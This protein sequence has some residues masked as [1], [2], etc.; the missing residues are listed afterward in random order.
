MSRQQQ[1]QHQRQYENYDVQRRQSPQHRQQQQ[2]PSTSYI[3]VPQSPDI[4]SNMNSNKMKVVAG[5]GLQQKLGSGSFAIVYKGVRLEANTNTTG[6]NVPSTQEGMY[7][8]QN[9]SNGDFAAIKAI[10]RNSDRLTPKVLQNLEKEILI[11]RSYRHRNIVCLYEVQ[12][13][14]NHFYL[15]LEYC[16]GGD[17]QRLIRDRKTGRLSETLSRRLMRDLCGGLSFLNRYQL[18]HRDI[19]PQNLLLTGPLPLDEINDPC[20]SDELEFQ[21]RQSNFPSSQF[22]LK[23]ADFG[24][25]RHLQTTSLAETLCKY[26]ISHDDCTLLMCLLVADFTFLHFSFRTIWM[27]K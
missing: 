27:N 21:R 3:E 8:G 7:G 1:H 26:E 25:A 4:G 10:A 13:T 24:F 14:T 22:V 18:I 2:Q 9:A 6:L 17:L 23:I 16:S 20:R 12:K 11:L 15:I 19:K 5:Y